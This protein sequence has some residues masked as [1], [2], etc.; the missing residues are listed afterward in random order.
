MSLSTVEIRIASANPS[1]VELQATGSPAIVQINMG[2]AGA[3]GA[4]GA[5][6]GSTSAWNY[7]AKTT[8][9]SGYPGNGFL[10]WNNAT[11]T[12]A[13][14]I[15][16]SHL[17]D[18]DTD[19]ELFLSF[20]VLNQKI[21]IQNRD[22][23][24]QN[25][26]WQITGTPTVTG[27]NTSTAYYT[28][29]VTLVSSAGAAFTNNHSILFG[30]IVVATNSVTSA[31][32]SDGTALLD[33]SR[34]T[35]ESIEIEVG[36]N[37][38]TLSTLMS[39]SRDIAFPDANGTVSL[40]ANT[41]TL[42]NKTLTSPSIN[43]A[44]IGTAATFNATTYTYGTGAASA[45]KAA[46]DL[47]TLLTLQESDAGVYT[48]NGGSAAASS[49][50]DSLNL[51]TATANIRPNVYRFRNWNR[52]PG[53]SGAANVVMPVSLASAGNIIH[54]GSGANGASFRCGFGMVNGA[55]AVAADANATT[56][57]GFGWRIAWNASTSKLEFNLWAH[58]GTTYTEGTGIDTGLGAANLDGIFN[59]IVGLAS[60]GTVS[61]NTWF[62]S[63]TSTSAVPSS[64]PTVT[65]A[66]GP[67]SGTFANLGI[68]LWLAATHSTVAPSGAQSIIA[69]IINRKLYIG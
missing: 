7:R 14:S 16:V 57:R 59:V 32:T 45:H 8:A 63:S 56:G 22:D 9:T 31:T 23:S 62:G 48:A 60:D 15:I 2:P 52:N 26:V 55:S 53:T 18:D 50:G 20:F 38:T 65:L 36:A 4:A 39:T 11:Q 3:A 13:T 29:P 58:N 10:L 27:A 28:F 19:I 35:A 69:K 30:Q 44:T 41:E 21:F 46:L 61:A 40:I 1:L 5:S 67:T 42:T 54:S 43:S 24:S 66:G 12:S 17:T 34:L 37:V 33:V 47:F 68:P 25:Q 6:G 49:D 64:T 51:T